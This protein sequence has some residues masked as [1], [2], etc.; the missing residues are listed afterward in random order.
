MPA[1]RENLTGADLR[2]HPVTGLLRHAALGAPISA[3]DLDA[4]ALAPDARRRIATAAAEVSAHAAAGENQAARRTADEHAEVIVGALPSD[5][6]PADYRSKP[7]DGPTD[8]A[9]LADQVRRW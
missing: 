4:L 7:D 1:P 9:G 6:Q 8:P 3:A 2:H 5:Q